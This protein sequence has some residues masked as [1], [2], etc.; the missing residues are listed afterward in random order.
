MMNTI[1]EHADIVNNYYESI[2]NLILKSKHNVA[3]NINYEMVTLYYN[4]G[5]T[6][7]ELICKYHLEASQNEIIKSFSN[8][9]TNRFGQGFSVPSLKK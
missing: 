2:S 7:N 4:I 6:I 5:K 3:K 9:L 8:K 1:N